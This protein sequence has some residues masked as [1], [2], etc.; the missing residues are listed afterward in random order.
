MKRI[1]VEE[2]K[3][4]IPC[5]EDFTS[6]GIEKAKYFTLTPSKRGDGWEDVTYYTARKYNIYANRDNNYDSWVYI[7]SNPS[8]P[9]MFKIGYTKN[10]PEE[11]AK[12][13]S[14]ATGVA[15]PYKVEWAFHCFDGF[16][17]EQEVHHKLDSYRV[18]NNREFF[19]V[20]LNEAKEIITE[21]GKRY[22]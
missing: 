9:N 13:L 7:L 14:K 11:R 6:K 5:S 18:S 15:L 19:Q 4:Y 2:A 1:T 17:L 20:T 10:L 12:Q 16:G 3:Q 8:V 22:V 21:L